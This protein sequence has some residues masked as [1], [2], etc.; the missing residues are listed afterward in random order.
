METAVIT[1][2]SRGIGKAAAYELKKAGFRVVG[3]YVKSEEQAQQMRADGIEMIRCDVRDFEKAH[4]IASSV[5]DGAAVLVNNAGIAHTSL[6]QDLPPDKWDEVFDVNCKGA[7][8]FTHALL[9][10]MIRNKYGRIINISS[11]WGE[12][13]AS[14]EVAYSAS[15]AAL[16]GFT[17]ALAKEVAP[18][19]ITVNCIAPGV[20]DTDMNRC[21][22]E[23]TM[24][25][26]A[27]ETP[28]GRLGTPSDIAA[29]V[30]FFASPSSEFITGQILR[31]D[32]GFI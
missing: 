15:K 16:I 12:V 31:V 5:G 21:Y 17:K 9:P 14:C 27:E 25:G 18:S 4:E 20:I 13:G 1:G 2:A 30:R 24:A 28:V 29:A 19:G 6:L 3:T 8:I 22:D 11:M 10:A 7:Y 32:G 26:L 23:Q